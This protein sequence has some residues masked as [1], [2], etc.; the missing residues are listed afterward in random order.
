MQPVRRELSGVHVSVYAT[1]APMT[2]GAGGGIG[3]CGGLGGGTGG[4]GGLGG[5][6]GGCG[7][8]GG[9]LGG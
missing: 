2:G 7:G 9:G 6:T 5:G 1:H 3:G 8:L 4:G